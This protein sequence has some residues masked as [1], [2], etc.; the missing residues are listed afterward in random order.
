M[1]TCSL[2]PRPLLARGYCKAHYRAFMKYGDPQGRA[3]LRGV[4]FHERYVR[5]P[6]SCWIWAG[7]LNSDG[8]GV[9]NWQGECK[10]HRVSWV[11]HHGPIPKGQHVLHR[12]DIRACVNPA[13]LFLGSHQDNMQ[14]MKYKCRAVGHPG[15]NNAAAKLTEEQAMAILRDPRP[16]KEIAMEYSITTTMVDK[17]R[18]GKAWQHLYDPAIAAARRQQMKR[19]F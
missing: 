8:Y 12:C 5:I 13:H 15:S 7:G 2:C 4:P 10:A 9:M 11:L 3:N 16:L 19:R 14:D 18:N 1:K 17:I 6:G